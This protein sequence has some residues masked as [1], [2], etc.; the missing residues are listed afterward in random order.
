MVLHVWGI[1]EE[2][3]NQ[4]ATGI[5]D[6]HHRRKYNFCIWSRIN[7]Y[8]PKMYM[9][10]DMNQK[11][12]TRYFAKRRLCPLEKYPTRDILSRHKSSTN[13]IAKL[14]VCQC[15]NVLTITSST[16][17]AFDPE[18]T[19]SSYSDGNPGKGLSYE[20][21]Y[22]LDSCNILNNKHMKGSII[23]I[24][25]RCSV[26]ATSMQWWSGRGTATC[27]H[28]VFIFVIPNRPGLLCCRIL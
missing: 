14:R 27:Q 19:Y 16:V 22:L 28:H 23:Y 20:Q 18:T 4:P 9:S 8:F 12:Q 3:G 10:K 17:A 6:Y 11:V 2:N 25:S 7:A 5:L 26:L 13:Y 24:H 21:L 1:S 15:Q